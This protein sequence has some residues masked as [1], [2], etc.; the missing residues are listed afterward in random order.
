MHNA[1]LGVV[2]GHGRSKSTISSGCKLYYIVHVHLCSISTH[3]A[4]D[5]SRVGFTLFSINSIGSSYSRPG[6]R[7]ILF[8]LSAN[9]V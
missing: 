2:N 3:A 8:L 9:P 5:Y 4:R 6:K 1:G 7:I